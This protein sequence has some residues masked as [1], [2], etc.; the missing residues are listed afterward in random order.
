MC[1]LRNPPTFQI[2]WTQM[3]SENAWQKLVRKWT[4]LGGY[5]SGNQ[6]SWKDV[7][8][9]DL[10]CRFKDVLVFGGNSRSVSIV[11][12]GFTKMG[13]N[14]TNAPKSILYEG[15]MQFQSSQWRQI[16]KRPCKSSWR[17]NVS[18]KCFEGLG[19]S[20][21]SFLRE[22]A[23]HFI[24]WYH[25]GFAHAFSLEEQRASIGM[26]KN[27]CLFS[28]GIKFPTILLEKKLVIIKYVQFAT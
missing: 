2:F 24:I 4:V 17:T 25:I 14:V 8:F 15:G 13:I 21:Q 9:L 6:P 20:Q 11:H 3:A 28:V 5:R 7:V 27:E 23:P 18:Y 19:H 16:F 26:N 1:Y 10:R 22:K 12:G